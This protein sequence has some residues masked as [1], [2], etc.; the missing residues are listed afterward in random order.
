M[1]ESELAKELL[2]A[3]FVNHFTQSRIWEHRQ[4][5][6][7]VTDWELKRYFEII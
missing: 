5:A 7:Q 2:G 1:Q 6:K 4:F 3:E